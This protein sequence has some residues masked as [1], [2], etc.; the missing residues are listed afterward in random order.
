[1]GAVSRSVRGDKISAVV[2]K[3]LAAYCATG[4]VLQVAVYLWLSRVSGKSEPKVCIPK[5]QMYIVQFHSAPYPPWLKNVEDI[6]RYTL[7]VSALFGTVSQRCSTV[8]GPTPGACIPTTLH[9]GVEL[10]GLKHLASALSKEK[11]LL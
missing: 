3:R 6:V 5:E 7:R 1:M 10:Q 11:P 2:S 8:M 9:K 4:A